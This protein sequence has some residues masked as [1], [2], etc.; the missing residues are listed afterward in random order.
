M[1]Q[2]V[3]SAALVCVFSFLTCFAQTATA[4]ATQTKLSR[5]YLYDVKPVKIDFE[6]EMYKPQTKKNNL[7][8]SAKTALWIS[9][10]AAGVITVVYLATRNSNNNNS[11]CSSNGNSILAPCPPGCFCTQ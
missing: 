11:P 1:L 8:G 10:F 2:K 4:P 6:K 9:L 3:L 5:A 7:S